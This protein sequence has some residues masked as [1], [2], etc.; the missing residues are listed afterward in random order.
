MP[1]KKWAFFLTEPQDRAI[2]KRQLLVGYW[3]QNAAGPTFGKA[4]Y[5]KRLKYFCENHKFDIIII[6]FV[7]N[8]FDIRNKGKLR[9]LLF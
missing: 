3:G 8:F 9:L 4:K 5:E 2:P 7:V 1:I 6:A